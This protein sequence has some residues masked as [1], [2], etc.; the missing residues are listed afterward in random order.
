[1]RTAAAELEALGF[2]ALWFP[3]GFGTKES[4]STAAL[5]LAATEH[6][7][8]CSGIANIW[9][10]DAVPS[11]TGAR[12]LSEAFPGRFLLGLGVSHRQ[13]VDPRGHR[14]GKPVAHMRSYL[15]ELDVGALHPGP[16]CLTSRACSRRCA[17]R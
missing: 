13:Q 7:P 5:V 3:E 8:V 6:V 4:F 1:M 2:G 17:P 11:A 14:Y 12:T 9:A 10:R 15:A 16:I